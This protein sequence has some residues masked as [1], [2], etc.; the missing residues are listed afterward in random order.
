[1][2]PKN[3]IKT[4][5]V[6]EFLK[7]FRVITENKFLKSFLALINKFS[8]YLSSNPKL[9]KLTI[10]TYILF[11]VLLVTIIVFSSIDI[12][13]NFQTL[14]NVNLKRDELTQNIQLWQ[15]I[16]EKYPGYKDA[17]FKI[18]LMEY[19][20]GNYKLAKEYVEKTL[21]LDP[22]FGNAR[23]LKKIIDLNY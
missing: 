16:A 10:I 13:R 19:Q 18:A 22:N 11:V 21:M 14:K 3:I 7:I 15:S 1:M 20:I 8:K 6:K 5:K 2:K 12:Y 9:K 23:T 4:S 17:Y